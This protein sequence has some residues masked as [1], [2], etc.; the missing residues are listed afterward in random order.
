MNPHSKSLVDAIYGK[1]AAS[2]D[3]SRQQGIQIKQLLYKKLQ[4][5]INMVNNPAGYTA[6]LAVEFIS[7]SSST[8]RRLDS[9]I[10]YSKGS[11]RQRGSVKVKR[12]NREQ[13]DDVKFVFC[14]EL[15]S[16]NFKRMKRKTEAEH[17]S[18]F[19]IGFGKSCT[20]DRQIAISVCSFY[21]ILKSLF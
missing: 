16:Q 3:F 6:D 10:T 18:T 20:K 17:R 13:Q 19:A 4:H 1:G 5:L 14:A 12:D 15:V 2:N 7:K 11:L 9:S 8:I 21:S